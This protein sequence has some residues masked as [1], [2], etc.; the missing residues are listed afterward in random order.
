MYSIAVSG[1]CTD[2]SAGLILSVCCVILNDSPRRVNDSLLWLHLWTVDLETQNWF[3]EL[4]FR[5]KVF[6][7]YY[8]ESASYARKKVFRPYKY[9]HHFY[10]LG[11][12]SRIM[13]ITEIVDIIDTFKIFSMLDIWTPF[14]LFTMFQFELRLH[15]GFCFYLAV[16]TERPKAWLGQGCQSINCVA[17]AE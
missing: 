5:F 14:W 12:N 3:R 11:E 4:V 6:G 13:I 8:T 10:S 16:V 7:K 17:M 1:H 15:R 2:T 9:L